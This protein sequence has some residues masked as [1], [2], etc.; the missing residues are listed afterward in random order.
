MARAPA[1]N[2][3]SVRK[4]PDFPWP[5]RAMRCLITPPPRLA[6]IKPCP[7]SRMAWQSSASPMP[8]LLPKRAN[9]LVLNVRIY[10]YQNCLGHCPEAS[11]TLSATV[12]LAWEL[13]EKTSLQGGFSGGG[14]G[15]TIFASH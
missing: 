5:G 7:A 4:P 1:L 14:T 11:I 3:I 15:H 2:T 10:P 9:A 13:H 8:A 6:A 12:D